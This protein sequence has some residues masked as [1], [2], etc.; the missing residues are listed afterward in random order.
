MKKGVFF[1]LAIVALALL[2]SG[3]VL[4]QNVGDS[5]YYFVTYYSNNVSGAPD[6][7]LRFVNDG[8]TG[9]NIAA[10]IYVLDDSQ[11]LVACGACWITPDGILSEDV[12]TE[13]TNNT[14]TGKVPPRG[15]IKVI[16]DST[17][18]PYL[19]F[20]VTEGLHGWATHI[21]RATP[22]SG[23]YST[24]ESLVDD[25]NLALGEITQLGELCSYE[26]YLGSGRGTITCTPED[27]DF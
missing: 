27:S 12:K 22:T 26:Q 11:E 5:S 6:A 23:A 7:T 9:G 15:V 2:F 24:T 20:Y 13:L 10:D 16:A 1:I 19:P 3:A 8:Y 17:G 14:L 21:E 4:A 25:A 18:D